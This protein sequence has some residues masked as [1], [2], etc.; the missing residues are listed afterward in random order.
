MTATNPNKAKTLGETF[1]GDYG[2]R[3]FALPPSPEHMVI[4]IC[5]NAK[6]AISRI[7]RS[8]IQKGLIRRTSA[9]VTSGALL[10]CARA[11]LAWGQVDQP[12]SGESPGR[13]S[14]RQI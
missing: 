2:V 1:I 6:E 8:P 10:L 7:T 4:R 12:A 14:S 3:G 5:I 9:W 13:N 11:H